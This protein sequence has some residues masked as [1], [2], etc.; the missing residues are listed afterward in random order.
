MHL[1][2]FKILNLLQ[3][4]KLVL[5][6]IIS[7][8]ESKYGINRSPP[9]LTFM[10]VA[11]REWMLAMQKSL[12]KCQMMIKSNNACKFMFLSKQFWFCDS[13]RYRLLYSTY[14]SL[15]LG[16]KYSDMG[17]YSQQYLIYAVWFFYYYY[18]CYSWWVITSWPNKSIITLMG[19]LVGLKFTY[20][21]VFL[22][23]K[24]IIVLT[25]IL[26]NWSTGY[27]QNILPCVMTYILH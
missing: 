19:Y 25:L 14:R 2:H 26:V 9:G 17:W 22:L 1:D 15:C 10:W 6:F 4:P 27:M 5:I 3:L 20:K 16:V 8:S 21:K 18:Y 24:N 13:L 7:K 23:A 12:N 11:C